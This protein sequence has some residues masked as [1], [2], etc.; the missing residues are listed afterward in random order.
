MQ[1]ITRV[2]SSTRDGSSDFVCSEIASIL[3]E[4]SALRNL[5]NAFNANNSSA[6]NLHA[7]EHNNFIFSS[8]GHKTRA[9]KKCKAT[10]DKTDDASRRFSIVLYGT[11]G[12]SPGLRA[13]C[14]NQNRTSDIRNRDC[15][16]TGTMN[17]WRIERMQASLS[18]CVRRHSVPI[19][20]K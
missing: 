14:V 4:N 2:V 19:G 16:K 17:H 7:A 1:N 5:Q 15:T 6:A 10:V 12:P 20:P 11:L 3:R 18:T 8:S 9:E 13:R